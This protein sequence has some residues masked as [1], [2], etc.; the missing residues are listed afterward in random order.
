MSHAILP[1]SGAHIWSKCSGAVRAQMG[2]PNPE[3]PQSREGTAAH[4]VMAE[5]LLNF[6]SENR[7]PL[8]CEAYIDRTAPNGVVIDQRM[9]QG[10]Q[11][12]VDDVLKIAQKH[13]ALQS[14]LVEQ[15]VNMPKIHPENWGTLD[16]SIPLVA[17]GWIFIWDYKHGHREVE[18]ENNEQLIDYAAGLVERLQIN[19]EM[20][21]Q[22]MVC[23]RVVMPF[24]YNAK[25]P[26][27]EWVVRLS[28]LRGWFNKLSA[29]AW[30]ALGP[31]PTL[32]SGLHCRDCLAVGDCPGAR[33]KVYNLLDVLDMPFSLDNMR[34]ADMVVERATLREGFAVLK[35]RLESI[36]ESLYYAIEAGDKTSGLTIETKPGA[37]EFTVPPAQA[38]AFAAQFG[39]NIKKDGLIT[40]TQA[41]DKTP[42]GIRPAFSEA[43]K[44]ITRRP[45]GARNLVPIKDSKTFQAFQPRK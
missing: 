20:D 5:V 40:P 18:V 8:V 1:P 7:G 27:R 14:M 3:T 30:E 28:D 2:R 26:I 9:A 42:S 41:I 45:P 43:I 37:L 19:G 11:V 13:G 4:W 6:Q 24:A 10:A 32:T 15:R 23:F 33:A 36:E 16:V 12:I 31:A 21:Q 44:S 35:S 39:V 17:A 34:P 29:K 38:V 22:I 25:G